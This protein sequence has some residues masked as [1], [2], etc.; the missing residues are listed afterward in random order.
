MSKP[1][2]DPTSPPLRPH[3]YDGIQEYDNR[4]PNW[5]LWTFYLAVIFTVIYWF[6]RY[7]AQIAMSDAEHIAAEMAIIDEKRLAAVGELTDFTLWQ[8]AGN[9]GFIAE[10]EKIFMD[11]CSECHGANLEGGIG[12]NLADNDWKWGNHPM[13][14]YEVIANGSPDVTKGMQ[15]WAPLLGPQAVSQVT[16]Y[17]LSH[18]DAETMAGGVSENAPIGL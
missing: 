10:G 3:V 7:D 5:W 9:P 14:V 2:A 1:P 6:S 4:L 8:M 15:A 11:K 12:L 16:A 17:V 13:S 18:H